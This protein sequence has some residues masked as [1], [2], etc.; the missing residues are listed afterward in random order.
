[1]TVRKIVYGLAWLLA[2]LLFNPTLLADDDPLF[3]ESGIPEGFEFLAEPQ[4]TVVDLYYGG[5]YL[6][7][8]NATYT[9]TSFEFLTPSEV[10]QKIPDVSK[11]DLLVNAL[12]GTLS[13][14]DRLVCLSDQECERLKPDVA[15]VVFD[16]ARF[17][18]DLFVNSGL[19]DD[20]EPFSRRYL[21]PSTSETAFLQTLNGLVSGAKGGESD[22]NSET[23]TLYGRSLLSFQEN[24]IESLWDYD[25]EK[26]FGVRTLSFNHDREGFAY[27]IGLIQNEGFGL[28]FTPEHHVVGARVGSSL[29]TLEANGITDSTRLQIFQNVRGRVEV[30]RDGRLIHSEFL[31][32]GNQLINTNSFPAG[33]YNINI[34]VYD[35]T[36]L[37]S[38]EERFFVKTTF[39]PPLDEPQYFVELGKPVNVQ[40]EKRFPQ[41]QESYLARAGY[42]MRLGDQSSGA[43]A[44]AGTGNEVLA[45]LSLLQL[46]SFWQAGTSAMVADRG[47]YGWSMFGFMS[48]GRASLNLNYRRLW[49]DPVRTSLTV[50]D[51]QLLGDGFYQ[52]A[53]SVGFPLWRGN[54]D[55]RRSYHREDGDQETRVVDGLSF[56]APVWEQGQYQLKFRTD[57]ARDNESLRVL[58]GVELSQTSDHWKNTLGYRS[59]YEREEL[60]GQS[61]RVDRD[62]HY[63]ASTTWKDRDIFADD[64]EVGAF[65]ENQRDRTMLGSDLNY[66]GHYLDSHLSYTHTKHDDEDNVDAYSG[67]FNTSVIT[68]GE[69]LAFGGQGLSESGLLVKLNGRV[70]GAF[71]ILVNGQHHGYANIGD[72]ALINLSPFETYRVFI[73][74]RG[75]SY[76]EYDEKELEFTLYPG[77]VQSFSWDIEQVLVVIGRLENKSGKVLVNRTLD[78]VKGLASTDDQG[79]FQ[80]R[81]STATRSIRVELD[82]GQYC[83]VNLPENYTVRRGVVLMG[84]LQCL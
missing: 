9:P 37:V 26:H 43:L 31:E 76:Y 21:P 60:K 13:R 81:V 61:D 27:G 73:R 14:N 66:Q 23:W 5:R 29:R 38:E 45:E 74:P 68:N 47:R 36:Q 25:K 54:V 24:N 16:E 39:L 20:P 49:S 40:S 53:A 69:T 17:R 19:L 35:G 70:Q 79:I 4:T 2:A 12:T 7:S 82:E 72:S 78:G 32:A 8:V 6:S 33:A 15:G 44:I 46:E 58:V 50:E 65:V 57:V 84:T 55:I 64:L 1:M 48:L 62:D 22:S 18:V 28:T 59:E 63:R 83:D 3:E 56:D 10:V 41:R 80:A 11:T 34:K 77:N 52:G 71:D 30:Y 67:G 42:N 75:E 51:Y